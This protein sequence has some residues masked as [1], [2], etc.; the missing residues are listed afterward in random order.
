MKDK[1]S[2]LYLTLLYAGIFLLI[3]VMFRDFFNVALLTFIGAMIVDGLASIIRK[4]TRIPRLLAKIV[5]L[6]LYFGAIIWGLVVLLPKAFTELSSFYQLI[7]KLVETRAWEE[8]IKGNEALLRMLNDIVDFL[9]PSFSELLNFILRSLVTHTPRMFVV[10][11]FSVLGTIYT[12]IYSKA[13]VDTI[14]YLYPKSC[15]KDITEFVEELM[16]NMRRFINVL[17]L[18]ALLIGASFAIFFNLMKL[19]YAP[20]LAFWGFVTN[21]IPIVGTIF[22]IVPVMLFS[23]S[24]GLEKMLWILVFLVV[25]HTFVFVLFFE[26]MKGHTKINPV[27]MI[28]SILLASQV[29]GMV[30]TF[31]GAPAALFVSVFFHK[32]ISPELER[33]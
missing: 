9:R 6:I 22:E 8:Y 13:L 30:G 12:V 15:R 5:G 32:F 10:V 25:M 19:P 29:F 7:A 28:F 26:L 4:F 21:F 20:L 16:K 18:N 2:G 11:F 17:A 1:K 33:E 14:P 3:G 31:F 23:L 24:L 27:L